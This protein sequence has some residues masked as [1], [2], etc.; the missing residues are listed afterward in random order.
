M[1]ITVIIPTAGRETIARTIQS[2]HHQWEPGDEL[3]IAYD[4]HDARPT[5]GWFRMVR[6][7]VPC[8]VTLTVHEHDAGH[9]CWGHCP[10]S[11]AQQI[12]SGDWLTFNDDDDIYT[13]TAL[14]AIRQATSEIAEPMPLLFRFLTHYGLVAWADQTLA[15]GTVG[16]HC[17]VVPNIPERLGVWTCRY[18]G[19]YDAIIDTLTRW[20]KAGV[21][22][23]G[24][25][26]QV[27]AIARPGG[28]E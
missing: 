25:C 9:H 26:Q 6:G 17:L 22:N 15:Q 8:G 5:L 16:G 10:L 28:T 19:D 3:L 2:L 23:L 24:W 27:I 13:P 14:A 20:R 21:P 18:E 4:T 7:A 12:A 1:T 11:S